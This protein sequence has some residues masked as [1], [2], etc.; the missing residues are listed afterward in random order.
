LADR[1][2]EVKVEM[3]AAVVDPLRGVA[4]RWIDEV[5]AE[6]LLR[7]KLQISVRLIGLIE[8]EALREGSLLSDARRLLIQRGRSERPL[9]LREGQD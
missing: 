7:P 2:P 1:T 8:V 5:E 4:A 9:R 3:I 6:C